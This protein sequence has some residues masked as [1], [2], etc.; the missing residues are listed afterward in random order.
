MQNVVNTTGYIE[1]IVH[2]GLLMRGDSGSQP[3]RPGQPAAAEH[4][5]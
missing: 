1:N 2:T 5:D 4:P 3:E